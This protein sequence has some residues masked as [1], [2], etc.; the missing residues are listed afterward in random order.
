[1]PFVAA[2]DLLPALRKILL[3]AA[4]NHNPAICSWQNAEAMPFPNPLLDAK[5]RT[6]L[7][8]ESQ[9]HKPLLVHACFPMS[10]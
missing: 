6:D 9:I 2:I 4:C 1:M 3:V 7:P 5:I 10:A 8:L